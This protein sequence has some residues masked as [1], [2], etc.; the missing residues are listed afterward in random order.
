MGTETIGEEAG[1]RAWGAMLVGW[2]IENWVGCEGLWGLWTRLPIG[3][4]RLNHGH[5]DV[6]GV[7]ELILVED[8]VLRLGSVEP[9]WSI[10]GLDKDSAPG[11]DGDLRLGQAIVQI[12]ITWHNQLIF[13]I[14]ILNSIKVHVLIIG[15][16]CRL[17]VQNFNIFN[18]VA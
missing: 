14:R 2:I 8:I 7:G 4:L 17:E 16:L 10:G 1:G 18:L 5:K 11:V 9:G 12:V 3:C 6:L 15:V 13:Q